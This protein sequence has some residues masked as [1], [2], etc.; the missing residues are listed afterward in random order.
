LIAGRIDHV[1]R[2]TN[3]PRS[4]KPGVA[5]K[6]CLVLRHVAFEDLGMLASMLAHRGFET[7][8]LDVGVDDLE[9][10]P[11]DACDLLV[12]LGGPIGVYEQEAYPFLRHE[13][14]LISDRLARLRPTLGICLGAQLMANAL[15]AKVA[16][17]PAKEIG[18]APVELTT[19]GR[20]SPLRHLEGVHVLHWH[21]DNLD[22]PP[23][24]DNLAFTSHCPFQA[25]RKGPN[26]L[27]IQFHVEPDPQRIEAW[28]IG[29]AIELGDA[30]IHPSA[31]RRDTARHGK[32]LQQTGAIIFNEW[33]DQTEA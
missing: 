24:C 30:K 22:L 31:I 19:A 3:E 23:G 33:L 6:T 15:G 5:M 13:L 4:T 10:A 18:W 28:L 26:L 14:A 21:G 32:T 7:R 29:H 27:G 2:R 8:Y 12:V 11:L 17:G 25:F 16:P 1:W 9:R 20:S